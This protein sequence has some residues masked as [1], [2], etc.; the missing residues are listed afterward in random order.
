MSVS[1]LIITPRHADPTTIERLKERLAPCSVCTTSE[2]YDRRFMDAGSWS[3]WIRILAQ[4]K[5]LY[6]QQPLFD[7]FYCLHL[8]LGKVNA[9][10]VNRALHIG[11]PVRYIDKNGT[12]RTVFSVEVVD[13]EDWATGWT[14]NHD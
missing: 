4:G 7:E 5:D 1:V 11:K 13:P 10:L 2:E 9:E 8:D 12:S 6:S 14:I 3:A